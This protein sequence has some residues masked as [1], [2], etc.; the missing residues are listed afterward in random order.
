ME[1]PAGLHE[2]ARNPSCNTF[3]HS[4][5]RHIPFATMVLGT[6]MLDDV[7]YGYNQSVA[8]TFMQQLLVKSALREWGDDARAAGEK[9]VNQL[10]WREMFVPRQML[11][12]TAEQQTKILQSHM[13]IGQKRTGETKARMVA[14][15][16]M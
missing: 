4:V 1:A 14:G 7:A 12:L 15:G 13:I 16:N 3:L 9:E 2:F 11:E 10:H 8:F 5:G 6:K